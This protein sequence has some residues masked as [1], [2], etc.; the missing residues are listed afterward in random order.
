MKLLWFVIFWLFLRPLIVVNYRLRRS[1]LLAD[2]WFWADRVAL[3]HGYY[4]APR[5]L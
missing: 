3:E 5:W 1:G 4:Y 2:R